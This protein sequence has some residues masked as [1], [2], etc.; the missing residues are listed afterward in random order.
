MVRSFHVFERRYFR[1]SPTETLPPRVAAMRMRIAL[2][3]LGPCLT[4]IGCGPFALATRTLIIEPIQYCKTVDD[5]SERR[6]DYQLAEEAWR[7]VAQGNSGHAFSP[8]YESGF[9]N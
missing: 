4:G 1:A 5:I 8:D 3:I 7:V 6:R 2:G 9:E